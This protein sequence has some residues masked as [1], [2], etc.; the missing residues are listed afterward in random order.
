MRAV[1]ENTTIPSAV[2]TAYQIQRHAPP[3]VSAWWRSNM[4]AMVMATV[5]V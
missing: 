2:T 4:A 1:S 5:R 3:L